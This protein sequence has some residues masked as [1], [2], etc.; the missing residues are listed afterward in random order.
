MVHLSELAERHVEIPEQV[1]QVGDSLLVKVIDIDLERRRI[2]LSLKQANEGALTDEAFDPAQYGMEAHY[3]EAGNYIYPEGFDSETQSW[4]PGFEA[5]Q[6]EWERQ[7][8]EA[9]ARFEAHQE[10]VAAAKV[11]EAAAAAENP[12]SYSSGG[13]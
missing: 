6:A 10:Q 13:E 3:D 12:S 11:A 5:Q 9:Q 8:A 7:Y 1:V 4:L 2:S